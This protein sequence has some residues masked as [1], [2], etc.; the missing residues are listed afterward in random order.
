MRSRLK[1]WRW[2]TLSCRDVAR[3][4]SDSLDHELSP[5]ERLVV[6]L[7]LIYCTP[8]RRYR[9][10]IMQLRAALARLASGR[11]PE[12]NESAPETKLPDH[13]REQIKRRLREF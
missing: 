9:R 11:L 8:C 10:Q 4:V 5:G 1:L 12:Q 2:L 3:L 6:R 13:V 7:H